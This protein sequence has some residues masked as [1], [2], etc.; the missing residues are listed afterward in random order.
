[1]STPQE[2]WN[3]AWNVNCEDDKE[4]IHR[5]LEKQFGNAQ[6]NRPYGRILEI[7]STSR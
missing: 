3:A 6:H 5:I 4:T 2:L 7:K 1:M